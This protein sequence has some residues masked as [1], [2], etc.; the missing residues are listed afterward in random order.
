M[1][2]IKIFNANLDLCSVQQYCG[3]TVEFVVHLW[4][5]I[6]IGWA[7]TNTLWIGFVCTTVYKYLKKVFEHNLLGYLKL[8][9][10]YNIID[11]CLLYSLLLDGKEV[12]THMYVHSVINSSDIQ[13]V[14]LGTWVCTA[15]C[16]HMPARNVTSVLYIYQSCV[17]MTLFTPMNASMSAPSVTRSSLVSLIS[18]HTNSCTPVM[19]STLAWDVTNNSHSSP[20]STDTWEFTPMNAQ[21]YVRSV[22]NDLWSSQI[23]ESMQYVT[24]LRDHTVV[25]TVWRHLSVAQNWKNMR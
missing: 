12:R 13:A 1:Q 16:F 3:Q 20:L 7:I 5:I 8:L 2:L 14:S 6:Y 17:D 18:T 10:I 22:T 4:A 19:W 15:G 9:Y 24:L 23:L 21:S 25:Q 11:V